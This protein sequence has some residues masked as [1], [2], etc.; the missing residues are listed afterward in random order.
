[1]RITIHRGVGASLSAARAVLLLDGATALAE[2]GAAGSVQ[3]GMESAGDSTRRG[4][5]RAGEA[6][7]GALDTAITTTGRA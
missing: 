5:S 6:V 2:D 7:G 1:M 3:S 4:L